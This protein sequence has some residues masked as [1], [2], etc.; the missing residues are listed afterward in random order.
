MA[1]STFKEASQVRLALKMKLSNF[2]WYSGSSVI[3]N[4]DDYIVIVNVKNIDN[5]IRKIVSPV[6]NG[7]SIKLEEDW[8]G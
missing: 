7:V 4:K 8:D 1:N 5:N 2:D 6:M 3:I